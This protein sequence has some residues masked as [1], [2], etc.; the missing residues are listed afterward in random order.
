LHAVVRLSFAGF[1]FLLLAKFVAIFLMYFALDDAARNDWQS[2]T[3][4][5]I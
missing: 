2:V 1:I 4:A 3:C 5:N